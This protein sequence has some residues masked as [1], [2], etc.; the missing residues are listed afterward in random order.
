MV[1]ECCGNHKEQY[2]YTKFFKTVVRITFIIPVIDIY[3]LFLFFCNNLKQKTANLTLLLLKVNW[4]KS[5]AITIENEP[6]RPFR[7]YQ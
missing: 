4:I 2:F 1:N 3:K 6:Y 7:F 5:L